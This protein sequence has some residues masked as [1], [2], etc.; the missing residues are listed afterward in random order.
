MRTVRE[1]RTIRPEPPRDRSELLRQVASDVEALLAAISRAHTPALLSVDVTMQQAKTL[2]LVALEPGIGV[3]QVATRLGVSL[4]TASAHVDRL[5]ELGLLDRHEDPAD[6]RHVDITLSSAGRHF[7]EDFRD[8]NLQ[9]FR[10]LLPELDDAELQGL[11]IA[12]PGIT[13]A[14]DQL[15]THRDSQEGAP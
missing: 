7:V 8:L 14:L 13:R 12:L 11:R 1:G 2:H 5:A 3:T 15:S 10:T 4:S 6:R 9:T